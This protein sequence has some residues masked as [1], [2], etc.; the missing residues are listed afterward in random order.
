MHYEKKDVS[1]DK[2]TADMCQHSKIV[3]NVNIDIPASSHNVRRSRKHL[4]FQQI[5]YEQHTTN[6]ELSLD[7]LAG[8][9]VETCKARD[10][11]MQACE[12]RTQFQVH[13]ENENVCVDRERRILFFLLGGCAFFACP[14]RP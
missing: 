6:T 2:P 10:E 1:N 8:A 9:G 14:C 3:S 7:R 4:Q 12:L 13:T 11:S 5:Q